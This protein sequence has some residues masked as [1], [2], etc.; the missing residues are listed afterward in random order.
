MLN[1]VLLLVCISAVVAWAPSAKRSMSMLAV[2]ESAPDFEL[3]SSKGTKVKL[4]SFKNKKPVVVF[5]Y[6]ADNS[7]GC[8]KELCAFE[9]R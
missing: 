3:V 1:I 5:F 4:S 7:P 8:T 9:K 2:G 6:P